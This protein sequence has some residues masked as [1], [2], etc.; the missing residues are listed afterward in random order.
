[1]ED[2]IGMALATNRIG[3]NYFNQKRY[4]KSVEFHLQNISLSDIENAFAGYYNLGIA[5]RKLKEYDQAMEN[6]QKSLE[7]SQQKEVFF[8]IF[9]VRNCEF[10][11]KL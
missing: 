6:F 5:Y 10:P 2:K 8:L 3:V 7:W 1:M 9:K 4:D 11:G